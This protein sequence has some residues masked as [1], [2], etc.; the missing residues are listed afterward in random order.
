M[1]ADKI[2]D[3][4]KYQDAAIENVFTFEGVAGRSQLVVGSDGVK[5]CA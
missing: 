1:R 4:E 5:S 2:A 3:G